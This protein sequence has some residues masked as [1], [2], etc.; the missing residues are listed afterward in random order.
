MQSPKHGP[1]LVCIIFRQTNNITFGAQDVFKTMLALLRKEINSFLSSLIGYVVIA[2]FLLM[3]GLIMWVF[4][5]E[6]N[7]LD[8]GYATMD[9]LFYIGPWVFMFL[10]PA[11]T[12]R[13]FSEERRT[14]T[15]ELLFTRPLTDMQ[16]I[17]AKYLAGFVLVLFSLLP[18]IIYYIS[19]YNMGNPPGNIDH[20]GTWGSYLGLLFLGS[21]FVAIGIFSS[22]IT[23][24]QVVAFII[25]V[26]L[27]F[28]CY[29][30][31]D[32]IGSFDMFGVLDEFI[33]NLG[34]D[35]HYN[36]MSRGVIDTRDVLYFLSLNVFFLFL[37]RT[38]LN[39]RR[40]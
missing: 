16:I 6:F 14:G 17:L 40:W 1:L 3:V 22:A 24:N 12:M 37:T 26:F 13:S 31:F 33:I 21:G 27:S 39:A 36:S 38:V 2:V 28:F 30:G 7:L 20:G 25:A 8:N 19:I 18:T 23:Q 35:S 4:S 9:T 15:I 32:A 11:I 34:I 29:T 10:I 5:G